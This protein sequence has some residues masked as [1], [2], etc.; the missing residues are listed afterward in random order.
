MQKC[1]WGWCLSVQSGLI[2]SK[3]QEQ[4][5]RKLSP[6]V[7][8]MCILQLGPSWD[9]LCPWWTSQ[10]YSVMSPIPLLSLCIE[11]ARRLWNSPRCVLSRDYQG[12]RR[13]LPAA[14]DSSAFCKIYSVSGAST[15]C[16]AWAVSKQA[17]NAVWRSELL[18]Q[19]GYFSLF[20][21]WLPT[22]ASPFTCSP[23]SSQVQ[24]WV[25]GLVS[26]LC[27]CQ[28]YLPLLQVIQTRAALQGSSVEPS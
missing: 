12:I 23:A 11:P 7:L 9:A 14:K 6:A 3:F 27:S 8:F 25:T 24:N 28:G 5:G 19:Q 26:G 4:L 15:L 1:P 21:F 17:V 20:A 10:P 2:W 18:S 22:S 16:F 13:T